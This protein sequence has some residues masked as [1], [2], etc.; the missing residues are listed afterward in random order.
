MQQNYPNPF[1][2]TTTIK[3]TLPKSEFAELKIYNILGKEVATLVSNKLNQGNHTYTFDGKNLAS[4]VYYYQLM[5]G[6]Y[7]EVKKM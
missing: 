2:P 3:F 5:A 4:G 6:D 7:R 1:N